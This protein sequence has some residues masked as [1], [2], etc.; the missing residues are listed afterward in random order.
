[1]G[2]ATKFKSLTRP[3]E[4]GKYKSQC[5]ADAFEALGPNATQERV[6]DWLQ[7]EYGIEG[8]EESMFYTV[9]ARMGREHS[10]NGVEEKPAVERRT[11]K[12]EGFNKSEAARE[13]LKRIGVQA[14]NAEVNAEAVRRGLGEI[15]HSTIRNARVQVAG[16]VPTPSAPA[17][18]GMSG[19][20]LDDIGSV[21]AIIRRIGADNLRR[22]I[23][24]LA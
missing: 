2:H 6:S 14:S 23:D 12:A 9:R 3:D 7:K 20:S 17:S 24:V 19:F 22:L 5:V 21:Q 16:A 4:P 1:V 11:A 13:I 15:D 8:V 18:E 10:R